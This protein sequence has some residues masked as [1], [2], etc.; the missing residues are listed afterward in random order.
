MR[1]D[2]V[3]VDGRRASAMYA[4]HDLEE[5]VGQAVVAFAAQI[6]LG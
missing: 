3:G 4:H 1:V 5:C 2:G 6:L